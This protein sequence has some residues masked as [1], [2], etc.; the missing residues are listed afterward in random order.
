VPTTR[1]AVFY[2]IKRVV[3]CRMVQKESPDKQFVV[4]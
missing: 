1:I 4:K 2:N 3:A